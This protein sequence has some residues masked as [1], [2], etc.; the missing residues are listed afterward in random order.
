MTVDEHFEVVRSALLELDAETREAW[1]CHYA[2]DR[3]SGKE[4]PACR[5]SR[6]MERALRDVDT[7]IGALLSRT[8]LL[9]GSI[10]VEPSAPEPP[11]FEYETRRA[12]VLSTA[13]ISLL[14][15]GILIGEADG[16]A[17]IDGVHVAYDRFQVR[18]ATTDGIDLDVVRAAG[19][20]A[21]FAHLLELAASIGASDL[22]LDCDGPVYPHLPTFDW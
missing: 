7:D 14:D 11:A 4:P 6:A 19:L 13:H 18:V 20:S 15:H 21:E 1:R 8:R 3:G 17:S 10:P 16:E 12:L 5:A 2:T 9:L 22:L